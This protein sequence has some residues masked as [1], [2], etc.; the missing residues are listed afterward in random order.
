[1][2]S[3]VSLMQRFIFTNLSEACC[4]AKRWKPCWTCW[5]WPG[6]A[7]KIPKTFS[8]TF[9]ATFSG[10]CWEPDLALHQSLPDLLRNLLRNLL[11]NP[12][13]PDLAL[14]QSLPDLLRNLLRNLPRNPVEPDLPL[15]QGFLEPSPEPS[16]EPCWTW[17]GSAPKPSPEPS[18]EPCW[19]RPGSAPKPPRTFSGTFSGTLLNLTWLCTKPPRHSPEPSEHF[20]TFSG[21]SLN[22]TRRLHQCRPELL[23]CWRYIYI[24]IHMYVCVCESL[25]WHSCPASEVSKSVVTKKD[26]KRFDSHIGSED[27]V[28]SWLRSPSLPSAT[29]SVRWHD[30]PIC[31]FHAALC[32]RTKPESDSWINMDQQTQDTTDEAAEINIE[33]RNIKAHQWSVSGG[34]MPLQDNTSMP[35]QQSIAKV[36]QIITSQ[37][38]GYRL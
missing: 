15:H 16:P 36:L 24:Y 28:P 23:G 18:P 21:T 2:A 30:L 31:R 1:M 29:L 5:T 20:G 25:Q 33:L 4:E 26:L 7:P 32:I 9:S 22:L 27:F 3:V 12:V 35:V 38:H 13:A 37:L 19:T 11:W 17:P 8:G 14:H 34:R 10:T 6:P